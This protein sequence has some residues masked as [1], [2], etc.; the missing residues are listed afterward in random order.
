MIFSPERRRHQRDLATARQRSKLLFQVDALRGG[1]ICLE[2]ISML[3]E[4]CLDE[5]MLRTLRALAKTRGELLDRANPHA[6]DRAFAPPPG[7]SPAAAAAAIAE[8]LGAGARPV[9]PIR[10]I[11]LGHNNQVALR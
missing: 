4:Q 10:V 5:R 9:H 1:S 3:S 11:S 6:R 2:K 7:V 8:V